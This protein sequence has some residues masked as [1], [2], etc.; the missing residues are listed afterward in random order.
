[1]AE[2][3]VEPAPFD[4]LHR[5]VTE[6]ADLTDVEDRDDM[7]V[8]QAG[9]G[10]RLVQEPAASGR[11]GGGVRAEHLQ[12]HRSV[13]TDVNRLVD[14]PHPPPAELADDPVAGDPPSGLEPIAGP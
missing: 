2:H 6:S 11:V 12:G 5:V 3:L 14:R 4:P 1:M 8:V 10:S 13:E 9:G 7:G